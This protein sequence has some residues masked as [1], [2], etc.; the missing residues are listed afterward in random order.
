MTPVP[1]LPYHLLPLPT[2]FIHKGPKEQQEDTYNC[3]MCLPTT[4]QDITSLW[5]QLWEGPECFLSIK[6]IL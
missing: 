2:L 1:V 6:G 3:W 5:L 4:C